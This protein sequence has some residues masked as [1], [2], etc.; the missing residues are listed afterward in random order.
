MVR[1]PDVGVPRHVAEEPK[2]RPQPTHAALA[3]YL[4]LRL[5]YAAR[6]AEFIP[7][8]HHCRFKILGVDDVLE[9]RV[10]DA[11]EGGV[12]GLSGDD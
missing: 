5:D 7:R 2:R 11:D 1:R 3:G 9:R 4:N 12:F 6:E 8:L 10:V